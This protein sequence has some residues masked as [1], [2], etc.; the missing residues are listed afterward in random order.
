MTQKITQKLR[1]NWKRILN[2]YKIAKEI[3]VLLQNF[4]KH[5]S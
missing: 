5:S 2:I 4:F 1:F 3:K